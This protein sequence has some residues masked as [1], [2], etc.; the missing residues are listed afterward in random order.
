MINKQ[1]F[2]NAVNQNIE[3]VRGDTL[4]FN[5]QLVGLRGYTPTIILSCSDHY[6][7]EPIFTVS[8]EDAINIVKYDVTSDT[9]TYSVRIDP[10]KTSGMELGT[11][12]YDME[13]RLDNDVYTLM[14]GKL[15]LLYDVTKRASI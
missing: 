12:Y 14:R 2:I 9:S 13:L 5:F 10:L 6:D 7:N 4:A 11:Y 8:T 3:M 15:S 1:D